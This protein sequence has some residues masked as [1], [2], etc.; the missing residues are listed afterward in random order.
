MS[1]YG[2]DFDDSEIASPDFLWSSTGA[3][4][5]SKEGYLGGKAVGKLGMGAGPRF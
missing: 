2:T 1:S 3:S 5:Q 4:N